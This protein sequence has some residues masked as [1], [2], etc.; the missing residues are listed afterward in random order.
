MQSKAHRPRMC[1]TIREDKPSRARLYEQADPLRPV[2][3]AASRAT[4]GLDQPQ[5]L[6]MNMRGAPF[7]DSENSSGQSGHLEQCPH[8]SLLF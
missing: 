5:P 7:G 3:P 4:K 6:V 8:L 2:L 1:A